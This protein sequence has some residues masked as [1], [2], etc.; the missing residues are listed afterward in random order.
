[1][2][3]QSQREKFY[4]KKY[5][6]CRNER[7][8]LNFLSVMLNDVYPYADRKLMNLIMIMKAEAE[9]DWISRLMY[10]LH[11]ERSKMRSLAIETVARVLE[12]PVYVKIPR[13][14]RRYKRASQNDSRVHAAAVSDVTQSQS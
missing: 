13:F 1:M 6:T 8:I 4:A 3:S 11:E 7:E 5:I 9:V 10:I 2:F 12:R 14:S